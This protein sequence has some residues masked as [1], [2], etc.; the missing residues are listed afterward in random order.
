MEAKIKQCTDASRKNKNHM[1]LEQE[2]L[3]IR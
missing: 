3:C 1:E 2:M